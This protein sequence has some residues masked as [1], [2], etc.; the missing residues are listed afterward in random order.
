MTTADARR[1]VIGLIDAAW[2]TQAIAVACELGLPERLERGEGDP[3]RLAADVEADRD[4]LARLLRGLQT[5]GLCAQ[6]P[7]GRFALTDDGRALLP[8]DRGSLA[9][10]ARMSGRRLWTNWGHLRESVR[11]GQSARSMLRGAEDFGDL[12]RDPAMA[13]AFN[14]AM[15]DLT[16]PIGEAAA[17]RLDW[18]GVGSVLDV[19]GGCGA[20]LAGLLH[21]HPG[22]E[23]A[24]LDLAHAREG[25]ES[26]LAGEGLARRA[27]YLEGSFFDGVPAGFD[28]YVLKS[29]LHNWN[30]AKA[31]EILVRCAAAMFAGARLVIVERI[32]PERPGTDP[33]HREAARSDLNMLVG[34]GGRERTA[35]EFAALLDA[36]G[37]AGE[38]IVPLAN[39][40]FALPA[41]R[42]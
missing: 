33:S 3:A 26:F 18:I 14:A 22:M 37:F 32:M 12:E 20:L 29:V 4:A 39:D 31:L 1:R 2:T 41:R 23:G 25:A 38:G 19:G 8:H 28:A 7:D 9:A 17:R 40:A 6:A 10:W 34:C 13:G 27:R 15:I 21:A 11:T 30:D 36:A 5:L 16:R 42:R 24:V 35:A